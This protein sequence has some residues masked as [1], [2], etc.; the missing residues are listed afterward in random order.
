[1]TDLLFWIKKWSQRVKIQYYYHNEPT[2]LL[3][4]IIR[5]KHFM[6][7]LKFAFDDKSMNY[8]I[9]TTSFPP[10][11]KIKAGYDQSFKSLITMIENNWINHISNIANK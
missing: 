8:R 5:V 1:M 11:A 2:K 6:T 10:K 4:A 3:H 9:S 7:L